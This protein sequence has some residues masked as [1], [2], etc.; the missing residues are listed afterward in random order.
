MRAINWM[1]RHAAICCVVSIGCSSA[2]VIR[3]VPPDLTP[4]QIVLKQTTTK[5]AS[6]EFNADEGFI[7]VTENPSD[8]LSRKISLPVFRIRSAN[9]RP[10]EPVFWLNGGPGISNMRYFSVVQLL[11]NHDLVFVGYRGVDGSVALGSD[12]VEEALE[13]TDNDLLGGESLKQLG[14]AIERFSADLKKRGVD[15]SHFTMVDVI[16]DMERVRRA[17]GYERL[18]LLSVSYGTRVALLYG[19][20]H[21]DVVFRSAMIGVN[22][23]GRFMWMP[24]KIDEQLRYY[25]SLF[26]RDSI[27]AGDRTLSQAIKNALARLPNRW[28]LH[29]LDPGK[30]RAVTFALLY[31]KRTAAMVFHSYLAAE[32][33]DYSGLYLMQLAYDYTFPSMMVWGDLFAK[34]ASADFDSSFNYAEAFSDSNTILGSPLS[35][36]IWGGAAG[37]WPVSLIPSDLR[38]VQRSEVQT[39]L[40]SGS[41]DFSTPAEYATELLPSLPNGRQVIL[42]E[43]GHVDDVFTLQREALSHLLTRFYDEGVAD[44]SRFKYTRMDFEPP[45]RLTTWAKVLYPFIFLLNL[46]RW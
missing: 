18:N 32:E 6:R 21:P 29:K 19:Y 20:L 8:S 2:T 24:Q 22:P 1:Q 23:P 27:R 37:R 5:V 45:V 43:M 4:G 3:E 12:E 26:V 17:L 33:G 9:P 39:L 38:H 16:A 31:H 13:G 42:R 10:R 40:I 30:I 11:E 14:E 35:K 25:D 15:P 44:D 46:F 36:L 7:I 41:I 28:M 34:G